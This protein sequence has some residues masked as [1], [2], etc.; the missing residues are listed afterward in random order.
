MIW[1]YIVSWTLI[2]DGGSYGKLDGN[3]EKRFMNRNEAVMFMEWPK[4]TS[5]KIEFKCENFKFDSTKID[6]F[7]V[8]KGSIKFD[9]DAMEK[10]IDSMLLF[11]R[12]SLFLGGRS[13][14]YIEDGLK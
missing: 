14:Q 12:K 10:D 11:G 9:F 5:K 3:F 13:N 1:I 2:F 4:A 6:T 8:E 7:T